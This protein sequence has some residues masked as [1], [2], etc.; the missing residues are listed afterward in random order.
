MLVA[1]LRGPNMTYHSTAQLE[2]A[3][4]WIA[5]YMTVNRELLQHFGILATDIRKQYV[6]DDS[7]PLG[8]KTFGRL[9]RDNGLER[10]LSKNQ[11]YY[12]IKP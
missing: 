4:R 6:S 3:N 9:L 2:K 11:V 1:F 7:V 12:T 8:W 10:F 5:V